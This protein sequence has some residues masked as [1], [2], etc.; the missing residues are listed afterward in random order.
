MRSLAR[1]FQCI[2]ATTTPLPRRPNHPPAWATAPTDAFPSIN[3]GRAGHLP[4]GQEYR[5]NGGRLA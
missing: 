5:T 2:P 3:S 4:R 1:W